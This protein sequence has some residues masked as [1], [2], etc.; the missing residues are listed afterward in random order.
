MRNRDSVTFASTYVRARGLP[1]VTPSFSPNRTDEESPKIPVLV[2]PDTVVTVLR[3]I[4]QQRRYSEN[5]N[6]VIASLLTG[7]E[8]WS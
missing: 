2:V 1:V 6:D 8:S 4:D 7:S 5:Y 3:C